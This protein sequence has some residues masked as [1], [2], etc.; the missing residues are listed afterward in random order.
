MQIANVFI[1]KWSLHV[2][3]WLLSKMCAQYN[4]LAY[5]VASGVVIFS[6]KKSRAGFVILNLLYSDCN[7]FYSNQ[8]LWAILVAIQ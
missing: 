6:N 8:T 5:M 2:Q 3:L 4:C 7:V 1:F